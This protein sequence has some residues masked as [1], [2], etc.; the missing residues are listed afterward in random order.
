LD[1]GCTETYV[2]GIIWLGNQQ[3]NLY[4]LLYIWYQNKNKNT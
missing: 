2:R 1:L 4:L 3:C